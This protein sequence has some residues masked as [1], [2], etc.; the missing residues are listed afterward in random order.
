MNFKSLN[1]GTKWAA[2]Q[3]DPAKGVTAQDADTNA[4]QLSQ[5]LTSVLLADNLVLLTGLGTSMCVKDTAGKSVAPT[6]Q[7]LWN[8]AKNETKNFDNILKLVKYPGTGDDIELLLS[9]CQ[10]SESLESNA[11]VKGF[12]E[13][14]EKMIVESCRF[15]DRLPPK[16]SLTFHESF[17]RKVARRSPRKPRTRLFTTNYDLCFETA[18]SATGFVMIDGFSHTSPQEFDGVHFGYDIVRRDLESDAPDYI[19]SVFHLCKLHG[20]VDWDGSIAG[21]TVKNRNAARPVINYPRLSKFEASYDQPYL[22]MMSRFQSAMRQP[23]T[24]LLIIGLGFNDNHVL[25]P[26][27]SAIRSNVSLRAI[28]VR[29]D[30]E[31]T[32]NST[33]V[34]LGKWIDDGDRRLTLIATSFEELVGVIPELV[35]ETEEDQH[36][37]RYSTSAGKP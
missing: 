34:Q 25:Q 22:E 32:S 19:S 21:K 17:L 36:N 2:T 4:Q 3:A 24:G 11:A 18:A 6:M 23:N 29:P 35:G 16:T 8:K 14:S 1:S 27:L 10:L 31:S 37:K 33:V 9:H 15:V 7:D 5:Q 13:S 26:I 30:A 28:I 20:S 12:I